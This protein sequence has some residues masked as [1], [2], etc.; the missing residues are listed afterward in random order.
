MP[1]RPKTITETPPEEENTTEKDKLLTKNAKSRSK[2]KS[3]P[4]KPT[5][6]RV[7]KGDFFIE[8]K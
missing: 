7:E 2:P 3:E 1:R 4:P 6:I 8:F 5:K